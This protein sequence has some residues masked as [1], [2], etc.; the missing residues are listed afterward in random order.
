MI[1]QSADGFPPITGWLLIDIWQELPTS[2]K[3]ARI[4]Q[5]V[6][7]LLATRACF[8]LECVVNAAYSCKV[9]TFHDPD[10]F[11]QNTLE[12]Y[13][14]QELTADHTLIFNLMRESNK[15]YETHA[16]IRSQLSNTRSAVALHCFHDFVTHC[17]K[18]LQGN[19]RHWLVAGQSWQLCLHNRALGLNRLREL[20]RRGYNFYVTPWS[21]LR[22][23]LTSINE[24]DVQDDTLDWE[25][26]PGFGWRLL[27]S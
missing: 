22:D 15:G 17:E 1:L 3:R 6:D 5:W 13:C 20:V 4:D 19:V 7:H 24:Q 11:V 27:A 9:D 10:P 2:Q 16:G 23:D 18:T 21:V 25:A 8:D 14:Y 26:I 12:L